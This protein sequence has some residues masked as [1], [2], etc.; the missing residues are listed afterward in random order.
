M[1]ELENGFQLSDL[2]GVVRRRATVLVGAIILGLVVG[3]LAFVTSPDSF[4]ATARVQVKQLSTDPLQPTADAEFVDIATET[5]L[6]KSDAVA[7]SVK[8]SMG[9]DE[10]LDNRT[11]LRRVV[12]SSKEDSLV[13]EITYE[14]PDSEEAQ[15]GANAFA[16]AYLALRQSDAEKA[17]TEQLD[18]TSSKIDFTRTALEDARASGDNGAIDE[19]QAQ[20]NSLNATYNT[21]DAINTADTGRVVRRASAPESVLSKMAL[22]KAV[23]IVG[24]TTMVGLAV[25]LLIDRSDSLGGGRRR[26]QQLLPGANLRLLPR[27][28]NPKATQAQVDAAIDRLAI[29]LTTEGRRGKASG[30]L[31]VSTT[32]EPPVRLAEE[33]ASSLSFAGIPAVFV[34]ASA[35]RTEVAQAR[36]VTSFTDLLDTQGLTQPEL[37]HDAHSRSGP[38]P[39][40]TWLRPRGSAEASGLLQRAV[41]ESLITRASRDGFQ[42]VIFLAAS[43]T[44]QATAA[45][46]ARWVDKNA[47]IVLNDDAQA[48]EQAAEALAE[49]DVKVAEVVWA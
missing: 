7:E 23:G 32:T 11:L 41:V 31:L 20:L 38:G 42:A 45:A 10:S 37:P 4:S 44:H 39:S 16:D 43:P 9:F 26:I 17:K 21:I 40:V 6:V 12:V 3:T 28:S 47:L 1:S 36:V 19:F 14:S 27:I 33:V 13:L 46:L 15:E 24:V 22:G 48:A 29:E 5:D 2:V 34:L 30:V 18:I 35:T 8:R 49:A 25:A